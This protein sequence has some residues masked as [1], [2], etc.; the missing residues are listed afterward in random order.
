MATRAE[1]ERA[2]RHTQSLRRQDTERVEQRDTSLEIA[3]TQLA[4]LLASGPEAQPLS[5][6]M[7]GLAEDVELIDLLNETEQAYL[8]GAKFVVN[9]IHHAAIVEDQRIRTSFTEGMMR[10][11]RRF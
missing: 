3:A 7:V 10:M 8:E 1:L 6:R 5:V 11:R 4:I 9:A 2:E